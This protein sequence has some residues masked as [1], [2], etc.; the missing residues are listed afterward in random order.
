MNKWLTKIKDFFI[1]MKF[2]FSSDYEPEKPYYK[3][4]IDVKN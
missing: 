3:E 2:V 4:N 1:F